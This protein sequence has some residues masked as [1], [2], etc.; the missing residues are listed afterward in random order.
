MTSQIGTTRR[1]SPLELNEHQMT[2]DVYLACPGRA[3]INS[4]REED[5]EGIGVFVISKDICMT[6]FPYILG[7]MIRSQL[8]VFLIV[9][10]DYSPF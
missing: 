8:T 1:I 6:E 5:V 3:I 9:E 2:T 10:C 7:K 4:M